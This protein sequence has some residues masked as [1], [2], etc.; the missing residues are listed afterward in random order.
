[1]R[2]FFKQVGSVIDKL[3]DS[4]I[5][6]LLCLGLLALVAIRLGPHIVNAI[7]VDRENRRRHHRQMRELED[8]IQRRHERSGR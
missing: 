6:I 4:A 3:G 5:F 1:M 7:V 8:K 2:E